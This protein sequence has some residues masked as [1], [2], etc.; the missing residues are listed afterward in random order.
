[1]VLLKGG[2][3]GFRVNPFPFSIKLSRNIEHKHK[4]KYIPYGFTQRRGLKGEPWSP[5]KN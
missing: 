1:M 5:L 2:C 4:H 3:L